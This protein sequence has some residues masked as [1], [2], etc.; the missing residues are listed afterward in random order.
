MG[1]SATE[2][3]T[4]SGLNTP[5]RASA[6]ANSGSAWS[7]KGLMAQSASR[8][9]SFSAGANASA[10]ASRSSAETDAPDRRASSCT[11]A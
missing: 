9:A 8:R 11:E 2:G 5:S 6:A 10:S 3:S 4:T 1:R 7:R